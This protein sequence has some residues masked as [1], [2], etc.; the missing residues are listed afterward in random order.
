MKKPKEPIR[1]GVVGTGY[2]GK[3][4]AEKYAR[5]P[6][7][8]LV[9]VADIDRSAAEEVAR[10]HRTRAFF[11]HRELIDR[12]DAVSIVVPTSLH[13]EISRDFLD[14]DV[15]VLIEKPMTANLEEAD[16]LIS[17]ADSKGLIIQVGHLERFN[18][19]VVALRDIVNQP[20]FIESHR[21]A[22]YTPRGASS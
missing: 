6:N 12:V 13:F 17:F 16:A 10:R 20:M 15:D 7:V 14:H 4:H 11:D 9:G 1:I 19:A 2:L 18:P 21:L 22:P 5:M 3:Y 8:E